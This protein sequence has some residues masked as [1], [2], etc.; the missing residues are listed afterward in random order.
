MGLGLGLLSDSAEGKG[1]GA[2]VA[3]ALGQESGAQTVFGNGNEQTTDCLSTSQ[4]VAA[5]K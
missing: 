5:Q 1:A 3:A 4:I 2:V